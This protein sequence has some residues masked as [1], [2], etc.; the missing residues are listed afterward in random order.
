MV[1]CGNT[2]LFVIDKINNIELGMYKEL[3]SLFD[4]SE[5]L[6]SF[7]VVHNLKDVTEIKDLDDYIIQ[8]NEILK[9]STISGTNYIK[10]NAYKNVEVSHVFMKHIDDFKR[11]DRDTQATLEFILDTFSKRKYAKYDSSLSESLT[12]ISSKYYVSQG[13]LLKRETKGRVVTFK[14]SESIAQ[15]SNSVDW[16]YWETPIRVNTGHLYKDEDD[17]IYI[18]LELECPGLL[19]DVKIEVKDEHTVLIQGHKIK[20]EEEK[21]IEVY[22]NHKIKHTISVQDGDT[23]RSSLSSHLNRGRNI[24]FFVILNLSKKEAPKDIRA[25]DEE[26]LQ[27]I[28]EKVAKYRKEKK[29]SAVKTD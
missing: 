28:A 15:R 4:G 10:K 26:V 16:F 17:K 23:L 8:L 11:L 25:M 2:I 24:Q 29:N 6:N 20:I 14:Y 21:S 5:T 9:Y 12:T 18:K 22:H 1:R 3:I 13:D 7:V 27:M 19:E